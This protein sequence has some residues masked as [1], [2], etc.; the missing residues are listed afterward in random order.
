MAGQDFRRWRS[1]SILLLTLAV[2]VLSAPVADAQNWKV[3]PPRV[4]PAQVNILRGQVA[5]IL[6]A[7]A[8]PN[9]AAIKQLDDYFKG[10]LY[11][12][13]TDID[14]LALGAL[15][16]KREDLFQR[17]LNSTKS[18][19]ARD[20]V[21]TISL[22]A[23]GAIAKGPYHP[24]VRYNAALILGQLDV[25]PG[26]P[27]PAGTDG[28]LTLL[29][30][31]QFNNQPVPTA[32][33]VAALVGLQRHLRLGA[34]PA[35]G[36]RITNAALAVIN[37]EELPED[38]SAKAYGWVRRQAAEV[39]AIQFDKGLTPPAYQAFVRVIGDKKMDVDDRCATA[40]LLRTTMFAS[41]QGLNREDAILALGA[42]ARE[43]LQVEAKDARDYLDEMLAGGSFAAAGG[44]GRM[45][46][47]FGGR[48]GMEFGG[49]GEGGGGFA[50][51]LQEDLGPQYEKRRMIDRT[52]AIVAG[53]DAVAEG[54]SD[55]EK[56][57]L[58]EFSTEIRTVAEAAL[59][60]SAT[61]E[62]ITD[63]VD[64]LEA[65][66]STMVAGWAPAQPAGEAAEEDAEAVELPE[67][68]PAAEAPAEAAGG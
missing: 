43:V 3:I 68:A 7:D 55:E 25:Q 65:R 37:R 23:M 49:R 64:K 18:Q 47:E 45:G 5:T 41:A 26:K 40:K 11:P 9:P 48:G 57:R 4:N 38:V 32:I 52:L 22:Q 24:A 63:A 21:N 33:K 15:S 35:V 17:Y 59:P 16:K 12:S 29:E 8:A 13:M 44:G 28:L 54:G 42:L 20:H 19:A 14:P 51:V 53:A 6:R 2:G 27:L 30:N 67:E 34:D 10:Y 36:E 62:A 50:D 46:G 60:D 56:A 39:L 58:T 66:I 61:T 1:I 31:D